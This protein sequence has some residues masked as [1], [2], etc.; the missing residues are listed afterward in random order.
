[1]TKRNWI[2]LNLLVIVGLGSLANAVL[3]PYGRPATTVSTFV[4]AV[5]IMLLVYWWEMV[6]AKELGHRRS[7]IARL[8]TFLVPPLGHA[9]YL[10]QSRSWKPAAGLFLLFWAG[11]SVVAVVCAIGAALLVG[12]GLIEGGYG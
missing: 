12:P 10:F 1:M 2:Y 11:T 3:L 9:I 5:A 4:Q 8:S 6:D 7:T